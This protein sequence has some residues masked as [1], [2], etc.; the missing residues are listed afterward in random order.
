MVAACFGNLSFNLSAW[1]WR[2]CGLRTVASPA[3]KCVSR[4]SVLRVYPRVCVFRSVHIYIY[5]HTYNARCN[6]N[7]FIPRES[8]RK[9]EIEATMVRDVGDRGTNTYIRPVI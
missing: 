3:V 4:D 6:T 9:Q 8:G 5:I 2:D 1:C 7:K